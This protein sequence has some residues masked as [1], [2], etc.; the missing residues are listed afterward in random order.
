[1]YTTGS[2]KRCSGTKKKSSRLIFIAGVLGILSA[3]RSTLD[4]ARQRMTLQTPRTS[5]HTN[6]LPIHFSGG[7]RPT[8]RN[9]QGTPTIK[10][11]FWG[12]GVIGRAA[13]DA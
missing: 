7:S 12:A 4:A 10:P 11:G 5:M 9:G 8:A 3:R 6:F 2:D 1:M 13:A